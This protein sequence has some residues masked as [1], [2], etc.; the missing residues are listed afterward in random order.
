VRIF[1]AG[2]TG[3]IGRALV[4]LLIAEGHEVAAMT[5]TSAKADALRA[6]GVSAVVCD[7]YDA[8]ALRDAVASFAPDLVMDQ[9]TDLPDDPARIAEFGSANSRMRRDG[10]RN[11]LAAAAAA[12]TRRFVAQSVAWQLPGDGGAAVAEHERAVLAFGG[13]ILRYGQFY[14]PGTYHEGAPPVPP[15][16]QV[17]EAARRTL[18]ALTAPPGTILEIAE[19]TG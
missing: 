3:V 9:L 17:A 6:S 1:V 14:G 12:G 13:V 5:R 16:I 10:T 4:P 8:G 15:C 11:L 19:E 2:A 7:A 18:P